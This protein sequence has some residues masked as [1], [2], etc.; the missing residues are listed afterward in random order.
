[1]KIK[2]FATLFAALMLAGIGANAQVKIGYTNIDY[3]LTNLPDSKEIQEKLTTEKAQYDKLLQEK[4][5]EFQKSYE[6][7][8]KNAA[9]MT[10]V[11]RQDK[12]KS[13]QTAQ[14][15]IQ[16]FQQNSEAAIQNKQRELLAPVM[17]KIQVAID[18]VAKSN[19][20]THVLNS[21]AGYG[22]TPV[23]LVAPDSDNITNLVFKHMGVTVPEETP[24]N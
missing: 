14:T 4:V 22:T 10:P 16:E 8:Q 1:M 20:Y 15:G 5:A 23:I 6:N 7:Y 21:D 24:G 2:L 11:I 3:I 9:T 19:G 12:E 17:D 18:E 13:L